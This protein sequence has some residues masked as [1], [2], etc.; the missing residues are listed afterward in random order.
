MRAVLLVI[1]ALGIGAMPDVGAMR[2]LDAGAHTLRSVLHA[3]PDIKIKTLLELGL[4]HLLEPP[5]HARNS[6]Q[7]L[8][9]YGVCQLAHPGAD[10]YL[11]HQ[12]IMGTIPKPPIVTLMRQASADIARRLTAA[13]YRVRCPLPGTDLLLVEEAIIIGDNL[14][15]D[16]G[17][18]INLTVPTDLIDFQVAL[19]I[20][21]I[22][23]GCVQVSRV[24][25]FGGPG[26]DVPHI[27][28]HVYQRPNGQVGVDSPAVGVYNENLRVQHLGYGVDPDRQA[29]S[30]CSRAGLQV[31]LIGKMADLITCPGAKKDAVVPTAEVMQAVQV[32]F[33]AMQ[34]G[35]VAA[36]V[37]ESDLAGHGGDARRFGSVLEAADQGAA[38]LLP[39]I[40]E[41]DL[42]VVCADHGNDPFV[43]VGQHTREQTPL[44]LY[45][46]GRPGVNLGLR[47]TL[48][49]VGATLTHYF[50]LPPTQDGTP[51]DLWS[52]T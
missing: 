49:D 12:E 11:G 35:L 30:I 6:V 45:R 27:L 50:N 33:L 2:P 24:I 20:G 47:R 52:T 5:G 1:D 34:K 22:V 46:R 4:G 10:S 43:H 26:I 14:E 18:N 32:E 16:P 48:A 28:R 41:Q 23:R 42:L 38:A 40:G 15:A 29:A 17:L 3:N 25:V 36:T 44:L 37:Q 7:S 51:I 21:Q 19:Q 31:I 9:S 8:A 39:E 13:G